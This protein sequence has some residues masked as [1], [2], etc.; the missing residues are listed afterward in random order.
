MSFWDRKRWKKEKGVSWPQKM[1]TFQGWD[2]VSRHQQTKAHQPSFC[3]A[4]IALPLPNLA[5]DTHGPCLLISLL[6]S[7]VKR[8]GDLKGQQANATQHKSDREKPL[9]PWKAPYLGAEKSVLYPK[10]EEALKDVK[11]RPLHGLFCVNGWKG[12]ER[13]AQTWEGRGCIGQ[14]E[15]CARKQKW[16]QRWGGGAGIEDL[17]YEDII[18]LFVLMVHQNGEN[19]ERPGDKNELE[20]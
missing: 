14:V 15:D 6:Q 7:R 2:P 16:K 17:L 11:Q 20:K 13:G 8:A 12:W 4:A 5:E 1:L 9:K 18:F 19:G 3:P 10:D